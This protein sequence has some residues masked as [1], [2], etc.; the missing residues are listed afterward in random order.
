MDGALP[1]EEVNPLSGNLVITTTDLVL[2]GNAG[3]DLAITRVYNSA[4]YPGYATGDLTL[5][6]DSWAGIGWRLHFGRVLNPTA[7][8]SGETVIELGDGS[9]HPLYTTGAFPEGWITRG[10]GRYDRATHTL[11]LPNGLVYEF[12]R[13]VVLN[14]TLGTVRYATEIRDPFGNTLT[15]TYFDS[16]GPKDGV[17]KIRQ[18]LGGSQIREVTFTYDATLKNLATMSFDGRTWTYEQDAAGPSGFG[19]LRRVRPPQ[20]QG[21]PWQYDYSTSAPGHELTKVTTPLGGTVT[22]TYG[23]APHRTGSITTLTRV[24]ASRVLG[25]RDVVA[26]TWTFAYDQ[27]ANQDETH[28]TSS[29]NKTRY[30][31]YGHGLSGDFWPWLAGSLA[32][33][34]VESAGVEIDRETFTYKKS[35]AVSPDYLPGNEGLSSSNGVYNALL[36]SRIIERDGDAWT[37]NFHYHTGEGT[38]NDFGQ[39]WKVMAIHDVYRY[40]QTVRTFRHDFTPY[41]RGRIASEHVTVRTAYDQWSGPAERTFA[42]QTWT[43]FLLAQTVDGLSTA[44]EP[45]A[46][47]N[48][49]QVWDGLGNLTQFQYSWGR[50]SLMQTPHVTTNISVNPDGTMASTVVGAL[51]TMY[52]YDAAGR[53]TS[54]N[55]PG[56][57]PIAFEYD[58]T[59][60]RTFTIRRNG[61]ATRTDVDGFGRVYFTQDPA[62]VKT[63][64]AY[65]ACGRQTFASA[66]Y[67]SG[68][69]SVGV[70]TTYNGLGRV[71]TSTHTDGSQT[72]FAYAGSTVTE[73]VAVTDTQERTTTYQYLDFGAPVLERLISVTDPAGQITSYRY[74]VLNNLTEVNVPAVP[75]RTWVYDGSRLMSETHPES[76]P[77]TYTYDAAGNRRTRTDALGVTT[78]FQYD[79]NNRLWKIDPPGTTEDV[80]FTFDP[81]Y[82]RVAAQATAAVTTTFGYESLTGRLASRTD[83]VPGLAAFVSHY[84]YDAN[85]LLRTITYPSGRVVTS[86]YDTA[87]RLSAVKNN[88][89]T[90]ADLFTYGDTGA[91]ASY[92]TGAVTHTVALDTRQRI[93]R[94]TALNAGAEGLDLTY[95]YDRASQVT[96]I[97]DPRLGA[98]QYFGYDALGRLNTATGPWGTLSWTHNAAGDRLTEQHASGVTTY[99]YNATTRRLDALSG[100][101]QDAFSYDAVGRL[102]SDARGTYSYTAMGLLSQAVTPTTTAT[103]GYD[104]GGLRLTRTVNGVTTYTTRSAAGE[105][106]SE[107]Q[108]GCGSL[109]WTRDSVYAGGRLIGAVRANL[110]P[111]M[112]SLTTAEDGLK[113]H[114]GPWTGV[115]QLT[116]ATGSPTTCPVTVSYQAVAGSATAGSDFTATAGT[117]TFLPGTVSGTTLPIQVPI[118]NDNVFE[119]DETFTLTLSTAVGGTLGAPAVAT[120]TIDDEDPYPAVSIAG[121]AIPEGTAASPTATL[122][123]TLS[124]PT[125]FPVSVWYSTVPGTAGA[126]ADF[127]ATSGILQ[128][129]PGL[130]SGAIQVPIVADAVREATEVF[131]V[132][133]GSPVNA[134]MGT[135]RGAVTIS[136]DDGSRVTHD[137]DG[138][139]KADLTVYRPTDGTWWVLRDSSTWYHYLYQWPTEGTP[140][141]ADYDGDGRTDMAIWRADTGVWAVR[142]SASDFTQD[143]AFPQTW[144]LS[145]DVPVPGDYDG[146]G[147]ADLAVY[148]LSTGVWHVRLSTRSYADG[149]AVWWGESGD[150]PVPGD[151]DGDGKHDVAVYRPST[152]DWYV[153]QSRTGTGWSPVQWGATGDVPV[154]GDYD[155]D[156]TT[157]VAVYRPGVG[158]WYV[159]GQFTAQWGWPDDLPVPA[160]FDGDGKTDVAVYRPTTGDWHV[161]K[162]SS[163]NSVGQVTAWGAPGDIPLPRVPY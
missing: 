86:E 5:E 153:I 65:D 92:R 111:P 27:G 144:G 67:T 148:R 85:D 143:L 110:A 41:I 109:V 30:R 160:D 1:F 135:Y 101:V 139:A 145:G 88:G 98:S 103:Y 18:E 57:N 63:R 62:G 134:T 73:T 68:S 21:L 119:V 6:E 33:R 138:D 28:V 156:G 23:D 136:N 96:D 80:T 157:D 126:P 49:G 38:F 99:A 54:E 131:Y 52:G 105:P 51:V 97:L 159:H 69:G 11:K 107:Y 40:R 50:V 78:E 44:Y 102:T 26:G 36:E 4:I 56:V 104:P 16:A 66:P 20:N 76:G 118:T 122:Q 3:F 29:C 89:A 91:L 79:Q 163:G 121:T 53:R 155:G 25:G 48:V 150:V 2:P 13:A 64:A 31:F 22:Y 108:D 106:L 7:T 146:D 133:L 15:F 137:Y 72:R 151:Y 10:L 127:I 60:G 161:L 125:A 95:T 93:Q 58:N 59:V 140:V 114:L 46:Q 123:V 71:V 45:T 12:G 74:D 94:L 34:L 61:L 129:P 113:E 87:N 42:Y 132:D 152:G 43:G 142:T 149:F 14:A 75:A 17:Q 115:V 158:L 77:T 130:T 19:V 35:E 117:L 24:V 83:T 47:G 147:R 8:G 124:G 32:E 90:F 9:R 81:T 70:T 141:P 112:I 116:T 84:G 100:A 37:T 128:I 82:G 120:V 154:P 55:P 162:S 39:P